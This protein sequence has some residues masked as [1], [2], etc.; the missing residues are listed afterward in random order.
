MSLTWSSTSPAAVPNRD[1]SFVRWVTGNLW[2]IIIPIKVLVK[3]LKWI[4]H[5]ELEQTQ[6]DLYNE[7][8]QGRGTHYF[9][10]WWCEL[11]EGECK[12]CVAYSICAKALTL[13]LPWSSSVMG[14]AVGIIRLG[15]A[16]CLLSKGW[17]GRW[18]PF[19]GWTHTITLASFLAFNGSP[20]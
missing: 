20:K 4:T 13:V 1:L 8:I 9:F 2:L 19:V 16:R 12:P 14:V 6:S 7:V 15:T 17:S 10:P 5:L 18:R 11:E 3:V